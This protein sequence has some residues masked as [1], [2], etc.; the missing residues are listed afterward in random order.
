MKE[1]VYSETQL[2]KCIGILTHE[3]N[4]S[5][6]H[7]EN[8]NEIYCCLI[9]FVTKAIEEEIAPDLFN[10]EMLGEIV[11]MFEIAKIADDEDAW[12]QVTIIEKRV[13]KAFILFY[14]TS[15]L[16]TKEEGK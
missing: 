4:L 12:E 8:F 16:E 2:L 15:N 11:V 9:S 14:M 5:N 13:R 7:C 3:G 6:P 10:L 1:L